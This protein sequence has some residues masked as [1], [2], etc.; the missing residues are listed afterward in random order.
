M[1]YSNTNNCLCKGD[2]SHN[3]FHR[4]GFSRALFRVEFYSFSSN[5]CNYEIPNGIWKLNLHTTRP[6]MSLL[7]DYGNIPL[8]NLCIKG[9]QLYLPYRMSQY[10]Q[11]IKPLGQIDA[12]GS[13]MLSFPPETYGRTFR[14]ATTEESLAIVNFLTI[15]EQVSQYFPN[16]QLNAYWGFSHAIQ[17]LNTS[18]GFR[19]EF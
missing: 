18:D 13:C 4:K 12:N 8:F 11:E 3:R 5:K 15:A 17:T 2:S 19:V 10:D 1:T 7:I 9:K 16:K 6:N 14:V